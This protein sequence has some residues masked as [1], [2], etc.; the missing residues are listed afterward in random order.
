[1]CFVR[2]KELSCVSPMKKGV[3]KC[4]IVCNPHG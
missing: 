3:C 1:M 2:C 4:S